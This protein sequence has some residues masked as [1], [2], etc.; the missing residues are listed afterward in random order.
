MQARK[1]TYALSAQNPIFWWPRLERNGG[2]RALP[3][4][5]CNDFATQPGLE[6]LYGCTL[7]HCDRLLVDFHRQIDRGV[8]Q[9]VLQIA[10]FRLEKRGKSGPAH[11]GCQIVVW[12][13]L[14]ILS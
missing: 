9:E 10:R 11:T 12:R 3:Y 14:N 1:G 4:R 6:F 5:H 7:A 2:S 8:P 13:L